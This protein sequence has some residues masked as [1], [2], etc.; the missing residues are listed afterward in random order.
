MD[1]N[2]IWHNNNYQF[3][4]DW[5][6]HIIDEDKA[7]KIVSPLMIIHGDEDEDAP[8]EQ[9]LYV[10]K[11]IAHC[12]CRIVQWAGHTF[13]KKEQKELVYWYAAN[14]FTQNLL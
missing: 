11:L 6:L 12:D 2:G 10:A 13:Y 5:F 8:V 4:E 7:K 1:W 3:Y 9:S 14:F